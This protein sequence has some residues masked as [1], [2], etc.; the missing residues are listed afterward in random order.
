MLQVKIREPQRITYEDVDAPA[1]EKNHAIVATQAVGICGSDIHVYLGKNPVFKPPHVPGHEFG[2]VLK[3]VD[4]TSSNFVVGNK[5]VVNPLINCTRCFYC[6]RG[7]EHMCENQIVIGGDIPGAMKEQ[8]AVPLKNLVRLPD[9]FDMILS[10]FVEPIAVLV[11]SLEGTRNSTVLIV[12]LGTIGQCAL[13]MC[14]KNGNRVLTMDISELP[15]RVSDELGADG[16]FNFHDEEKIEKL[17]AFLGGNKIDLVVMTFCSRETMDFAVEVV[18]RTGEIKL[19]GLPGSNYIANTFK[20]L[21]KELTLSSAYQYRDEE[22]VKA[23]QYLIDQEIDP[24]P[25]VTKVFPL[26]KAAQAFRHKSTEPSVKIILR[27]ESV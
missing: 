10:P 25:L 2:G 13:L 8:I 21:T 23:A 26:E 17:A 5:V 15:L 20:I 4:P 9:D 7:L 27:N 6:V 16:T 1:P 12:G 3:W 24:L 18:K 11:H 22:F 14:K 19:I